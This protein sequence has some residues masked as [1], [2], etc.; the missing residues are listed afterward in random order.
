MQESIAINQALPLA[1][2]TISNAPF[3]LAIHAERLF[4]RND[5]DRFGLGIN[6]ANE[7]GGLVQFDCVQRHMD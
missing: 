1:M 3:L 2:F 4:C 5:Y 6:H 7:W